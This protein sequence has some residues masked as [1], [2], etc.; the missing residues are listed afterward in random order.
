MK[1]K[2]IEFGATRTVKLRLASGFPTGLNTGLE[3]ELRPAGDSESCLMRVG[4]SPV[5]VTG[6]TEA[7]R[8]SLVEVLGRDLPRV[9]VCVDASP[10]PPDPSVR[11]VIREFVV[12]AHVPEIR[13]G[14]GVDVWPAIESFGGR[15]RKAG[16]GLSGPLDYLRDAFLLAS[17]DGQSQ[18]A[19]S[20]MG[21]REGEFILVAHNMEARCREVI[22]PDGSVVLMLEE[23]KR[24]K[25]NTQR[26]AIVE[27][28]IDF[29]DARDG[30]WSHPSPLSSLNGVSMSPTAYFATWDRYQQHFEQLMADRVAKFGLLR[31]ENAEPVG[32]RTYDLSLRDDASK[33][34]QALALVGEDDFLRIARRP[35][36]LGRE[37]A[38]NE[39]DADDWQDQ[40]KHDSEA[41]DSALA[42]S[43]YPRSRPKA[44]KV[45]VRRRSAAER[46]L[47]VEVHDGM[48]PPKGVLA[49]DVSGDAKV[50][51]RRSEARELLSTASNP[52]PTL[53]LIIE[54]QMPPGVRFPS[55]PALTPVVR[56]K[57]FPRTPPTARQE[58]AIRV[59]LNT[60]DIAL[61]QGPPGTGKTTVIRAIVERLNEVLGKDGDPAG[62]ILVSGFQHVA[63]ENALGRIDILGLPSIKFGKSNKGDAS[64]KVELW[65]RSREDEV[66]ARTPSLK[67][68][69]RQ[70][71][72]RNLVR[73]YTIA[74]WTSE[75]LPARLG[76][77]AVDLRAEGLG[78]LADEVGEMAKDLADE[79]G[80]HRS[81]EARER[82]RRTWALRVSETAFADDGARNAARL[83]GVLP[84]RLRSDS[85]TG[86]LLVQ[87]AAWNEEHA[88]PFLG[89]LRKLRRRLL[90][91]FSP[92]PPA[93][94]VAGVARQDVCE[95]LGRVRDAV[96]RN[97][98]DQVVPADQ[99]LLDYIFEL[100]NAPNELR[101]A[102]NVYTRVYGATCQQAA[103][104]EI[105]RVKSPNKE[106]IVYDT[107]L[108]DEAARALPLDLMVPMAQA[109]RRVILVGDHRQL[110]HMV[111][112]AIVRRMD[113]DD[114]YK[115]VDVGAALEKSLFERMFDSLREMESLPGGVPRTVTLD[116]Q[117]RTHPVLGR[118]VSE[119]FYNGQV[120]SP[121]DASY[122]EHQL[123][124]LAGQPAAWLAVPGERGPEE[125]NEKKSWRRRA[126]ARALAAHLKA[127]L[128]E[129]AAKTLS[130]GVI[131]FYSAQELAIKEALRELG[132]LV[133]DGDGYQTAEAYRELLDSRG[134]T[135]E[136]ERLLVG[137]VDAFQGREFDVVY[138][139]IVRS[140][141]VGKF[142]HLALPNRLCVSMSRQKRL[143]IA[144]G[145]PCIT[146]HKSASEK[147]APIVAFL[148]LCERA[149]TVV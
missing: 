74:P 60:P 142:G 7:D 61:I 118:F 62:Q 25:G 143:L 16:G 47:R 111:E 55:L 80:S 102:I 34:N 49:L 53:G 132:V 20:R 104:E 119:H 79:A 138:L 23:V 122:F 85:D 27:G 37:F 135:V 65:A 115:D 105:K 71:R 10:K 97:A 78:G 41:G 120:K 67:R 127:M 48:P 21:Q 100:R 43:P 89:A 54:G 63:V 139:S 95:L 64:S 32:N 69:E 106:A 133:R 68:S 58:E 146:R 109:R 136:E 128:D 99:V 108:I 1:A 15:A 82:L 121:L 134:R 129:P 35:S 14:V 84:D 73:D 90:A 66:R 12:M 44:L 77:V 72:L 93:W 94:L 40:A 42:P 9:V 113:A 91:V 6:W 112:E 38:D 125:Q 145:D 110:P 141:H 24:R 114:D 96:D 140:N 117:Y 45:K 19:F 13:I 57:V 26:L 46:T 87:A 126:E 124:G 144:V 88:P 123:P 36:E 131:T 76:G 11:V 86:G 3:V 8:A 103:G 147:I 4:G 130:F 31:Y 28:L 107:V 5:L 70:Q 137:T 39:R 149:G 75:S 83:F 22:R 30:A 148:E 101:N 92:A 56:D 33:V 2:D 18:R 50:A 116:A 51:Q 81:L 29:D 52:M 98:R 17:L 59:A